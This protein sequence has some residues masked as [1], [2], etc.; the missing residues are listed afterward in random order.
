M[1]PHF[2]VYVGSGHRSRCTEMKSAQRSLA[3]S[4][5]TCFLLLQGRPEKAASE[6]SAFGSREQHLH[7]NSTDHSDVHITIGNEIG[8]RLF[9]NDNTPGTAT[10]AGIDAMPGRMPLPQTRRQQLDSCEDTFGLVLPGQSGPLETLTNT[11]SRPFY[12]PAGPAAAASGPVDS[13]S[14]A[15]VDGMFHTSMDSAAVAALPVVDAPFEAHSVARCTHSG[16]ASPS[17]TA[18]PHPP[19]APEGPEDQAAL[20][21]LQLHQCTSPSSSLQRSPFD[22]ATLPVAHYIYR[23]SAGM[24]AQPSSQ[25][26]LTLGVTHSTLSLTGTPQQAVAATARTSSGGSIRRLPPR[27][28]SRSQ[29]GSRFMSSPFDDGPAHSRQLSRQPSN[30]SEVPQTP[31]VPAQVA[32]TTSAFDMEPPGV[33]QRSVGQPRPWIPLPPTRQLTESVNSSAQRLS[34][35]GISGEMS[36]VVH[37]AS[38]PGLV[39]SSGNAAAHLGALHGSH[40]PSVEVART[41]SAGG[42]VRLSFPGHSEHSGALLGAGPTSAPHLRSIFDNELPSAGIATE[43]VLPPWH[44]RMTAYSSS[45]GASSAT[46]G[47]PS[48]PNFPSTF[49]MGAP[50][51]RSSGG[52]SHRGL[53]TNVPNLAY[54]RASGVVSAQAS[55][56]NTPRVTATCDTVPEEPRGPFVTQPHIMPLL[57]STFDTEPPTARAAAGSP[58]RAPVPGVPRL[59]S[60]FDTEPTAARAS[61]GGVP[62]QST[63]DSHSISPHL[64]HGV[65]DSAA[66]RMSARP[67]SSV[68]GSSA[69]H[70]LA[71]TF[72]KEPSSAHSGRPPTSRTPSAASVRHHVP[73]LPLAESSLGNGIRHVSSAVPS[74]PR[75]DRLPST[76][77]FEPSAASAAQAPTGT[78]RETSMQLRWTA[79]GVSEAA[80]LEPN[81]GSQRQV[82]ASVD[83]ETDS[84]VAS[85]KQVVSPLLVKAQLVAAGAVGVEDQIGEGGTGILRNRSQLPQPVRSLRLHSAD[86]GGQ[87]SCPSSR[88]RQLIM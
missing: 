15:A 61:A 22:S 4:V 56:R 12:P 9:N 57:T 34:D 69:H 8:E 54:E 38:Y 39:G 23:T 63:L 49:D 53:G 2:I 88:V 5:S 75:A 60:T 55:G 41:V 28:P 50:S 87:S 27:Q 40:G 13:S 76:F 85:R 86:G 1:F 42:V 80:R 77:D 10:V 16:T 81:G 82:P 30:A 11:S 67:H 47:R 19:L 29:S 62:R 59:A 36:R 26:D 66:A 43:A 73:S 84:R 33:R 68:A 18:S 79:D 51:T 70:H 35:L 32:R 48:V 74:L 7:P 58:L 45:V 71:S 46:S 20:R 44:P 17:N 65:A 6:A 31:S 64:L 21:R 37:A 3:H 72:D 24:P 78:P 25:T 83:Y 52:V 14:N